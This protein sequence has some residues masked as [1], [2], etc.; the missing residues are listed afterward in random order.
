MSVENVEIARAAYEAFRRADLKGVG[1]YFA[2]DVVWETPDTLPT[3]GVFRGRD[4]VLGN[5][6]ELPKYWS[7]FSVDPDEYIDAGDHVVVRGLQ[8]VTGPGGSTES[9]YLHLI[10]LSNGKITRGEY[11]A[12]TVKGIQALGS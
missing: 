6:A 4:A 8:S 1:E 9:R 2:D 5:F 12:D 11:I 10:T 7:K 3:G